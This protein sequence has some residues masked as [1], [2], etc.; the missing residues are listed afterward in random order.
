MRCTSSS[1]AGGAE[2]LG[3]HRAGVGGRSS[4]R[5]PAGVDGR[6]ALARCAVRS[7]WCSRTPYGTLDLQ[8]TVTTIVTERM[9]IHRRPRRRLR[10]EEVL[11]DVGLD[12]ATAGR[13]P[14]QLSG[15]AAGPPAAGPGPD[16]S[17]RPHA[18]AGEAGVALGVLAEL[19]AARAGWARAWSRAWMVHT[20]DDA[21]VS[22]P[23]R[24]GSHPRE[25]E[26]LPHGRRAQQPV[27]RLRAVLE[28]A[29]GRAPRV[30]HPPVPRGVRQALPGRRG[31]RRPGHPLRPGPGPCC[32]SA[33]WTTRT[34]AGP[35]GGHTY[36]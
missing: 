4:A 3:T 27:H 6:A 28:R 36:V 8:L 31:G 11:A 34:C 19:G 17:G 22:L 35:F 2:P 20:E 32:H 29:H 30:G 12:A 21:G 7:R 15:Q 13:R 1:G 33:P 16:G 5:R 23:D 10:T 24:P 25:L 26:V 9:R 18:A 14:R